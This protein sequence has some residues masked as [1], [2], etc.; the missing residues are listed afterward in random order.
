MEALWF[1]G[2]FQL[3]LAVG[4]VVEVEKYKPDPVQSFTATTAVGTDGGCW[5]STRV[6]VDGDINGRADSGGYRVPLGVVIGWFSRE[7]S[8]FQCWG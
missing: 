7:D 6:I 4:S 2:G 8:R 5:G 1:D 3:C